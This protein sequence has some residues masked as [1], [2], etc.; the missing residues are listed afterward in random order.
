M[1]LY[2]AAVPIKKSELPC[3]IFSNLVASCP[4]KLSVF[5]RNSPDRGASY[6]LRRLSFKAKYRVAK[7]HGMPCRSS[8]A[9]E[10]LIT[11]LFCGKWPL[12]I[13]HLM[14]LRHPVSRI[15]QLQQQFE[16]HTYLYIPLYLYMF[17]LNICIS[18]W[19][20]AYLYTCIHMFI[21]IFMCIYTGGAYAGSAGSAAKRKGPKRANARGVRGAALSAWFSGVCV[22]THSHICIHIYYI[23][24]HICIHI[25]LYMYIHVVFRSLYVCMYV[26]MPRTYNCRRVCIHMCTHIYV[27]VWIYLC[28]YV[29]YLGT[30][31]LVCMYT[32]T[33]VYRSCVYGSRRV[34]IDMRTHIYIYIC[35]YIYIY[36]YIYVYTYVYIY[37][38]VYVCIYICIYM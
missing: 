35:V 20:N 1:Y 14:G 15:L 8:F 25:Y 26:Y 38:C 10:P 27:H 7:T 31:I 33:Y 5:W 3:E 24:S 4:L 19:I 21:F 34:C 13:R 6:M 30:C 23:H 29:S 12:M 28:I 2:S 22:Y 37:V 32:Y 16:T 9:K 11:G 36:I 18:T 17:Y